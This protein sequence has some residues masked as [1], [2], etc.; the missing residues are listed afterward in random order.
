MVTLLKDWGRLVF[1]VDTEAEA[2]TLPTKTYK[3]SSNCEIPIVP[4]STALVGATGTVF[5]F[6]GDAKAWEKVGG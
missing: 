4:W 2:S 5:Y 3:M 6:N 1:G